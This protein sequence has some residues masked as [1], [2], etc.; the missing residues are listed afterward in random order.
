MKYVNIIIIMIFLHTN[1]SWAG[2]TEQASGTSATLKDKRSYSLGYQIG[3]D[4]KKQKSTI[5]FQAFLKGMQDSLA[6]EP[7]AVE[8]QEMANM[9]LDMKKRVLVQQRKEQQEIKEKFHAAAEKFFAENARKEG[10]VVLPSGLQYKIIKKGAGKKPGL[11]DRVTVHYTGTFIDGSEFG[12]TS[13]KDEPQTF[14]VNKVIP[15]L[16]EG[17]QLMPQGAHYMFYVP[18]DLAY[19]RRSPLENRAVIFDLELLAV[20]KSVK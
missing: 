18:A 15:G 7:P 6:D 2:D 9:L 11:A 1:L 14:T 10:V 4:Y 8:R 16:A 17:L 13:Y 19:G 5:D 3:M 20:E 12:G